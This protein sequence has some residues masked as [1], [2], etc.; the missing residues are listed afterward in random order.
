VGNLDGDSTAEVLTGPGP[1]GGPHV[2][3]FNINADKSKTNGAEFMAYNQAFTGGVNVAI[4]DVDNDGVNEIITGAGP[5]GGPHIRVFNANGT[6]FKDNLGTFAYVQAF[7]GG[8]D[9]AAADVDG[10][11]FDEIITGAGPGGGPHVRVF[12]VNATTGAITAST[13]E[14]MAY[15]EGFHGGVHVAAGDLD[16]NDSAAEIVTGAGAG[17]APHVRVFNGNGTPHSGVAGSGWMAY[18]EAFTGGVNVGVGNVAGTASSAL[19]V[20][21]GPGAGGGPHVKVFSQSGQTVLDQY[22]AFDPSFPGGVVVGAGN[23]QVS[24]NEVSGGEIV[25]GTY[26]QGNSINGRRLNS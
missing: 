20:I 14:F 4:G 9:V 7:S 1:G 17:G 3:T 18:A 24:A 5:G 15:S 19:E 25:N 26:R 16:A 11:G 8:V 13:T 23:V 21:T 12:N 22:M 6:P 10:D 2:R